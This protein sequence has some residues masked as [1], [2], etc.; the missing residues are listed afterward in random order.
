MSDESMPRHPEDRPVVPESRR[1]PRQA[2]ATATR[3]RLLDAGFEAFATKGFDGVNLVEDVI[4]PAG[5]SVGSFYHQF[6]D[7]SELLREILVE[8]AA[9]RRTFIVHLTELDAAT[10]FEST[11][12]AVIERLVDSLERDEAA[13][14]LQR[15]SRV[16]G[17]DAA[18]ELGPQS[19]ENW[20]G[21]LAHLLGR[22]FGNPAAD[23]RRASD[24]LMTLARG[25]V[26]DVLD[27]PT[28]GGR[29]QPI[30]IDAFTAF[31]VGGLTSILGPPRR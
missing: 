28:S 14:R 8:A 22:W 31:A 21:A 15:L 12:R 17:V 26:S 24:V 23:L 3:R 1:A 13:W 11:V 2:R 18:R 5:I 29:R 6:A 30:D 19:R 4:E 25:F 16:I 27:T 10:D 7:K 20:N 9:R